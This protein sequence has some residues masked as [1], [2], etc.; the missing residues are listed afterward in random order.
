VL[1]IHSTSSNRELRISRG[2]GGYFVVEIV[3]HRVTALTEVW[4]D[5]DAAHLGRFFVD[6]GNTERPWKSV[7]EWQSLEGDLRF[8]VTCTSLGNV[9]FNICLS[10]MPGAPE[11][12][13]VRVGLD[14][15]L[16]Q[17]QR[18]GDEAEELV[19]SKDA[20]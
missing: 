6:L 20:L 18:I 16:G 15:E 11:E 9:T 8:S 1:S 13:S 19:K 14:T 10:G 12:W 17:L 2:D 5:D 7:R 3:G 4:T